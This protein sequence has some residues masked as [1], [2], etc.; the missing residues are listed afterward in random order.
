MGH[1]IFQDILIIFVLAIPVVML[2]HLLRLPSIIGFLTT[3]AIIGPYG[4]GLIHDGAQIDVL[5]E[6][7]VTLLLFVVG[8]EFSFTSLQKLKSQSL[9]GGFLQVAGT[10]IIGVLIGKAL[11]WNHYRVLY[12]GCVLALSSTALVI[13]SLYHNKMLDSLSGQLSTAILIFQDLVFFPM[14]IL[15]PMLAVEQ[16]APTEM[17]TLLKDAGQSLILIIIVTIFGR[18]LAKRILY[19]IFRARSRELLVITIMAVALGMAWLTYRLGFSPALGAFLGG[20]MLGGTEFKYQALSEISPFRYCF[21]SIFFVSIGMLFNFNFVL[22]YWELVLIFALLIPILKASV[23]TLAAILIRVPIRLALVVGICL[24][25]IGEFSFL[26]AYSGQKV[27]V[28]TPFFY[29]LIVVSAVISMVMTPFLV[30]HAPMIADRLIRLPGFRYLAA[31]KQEEA[32]QAKS[33]HLRDHII[34]CGFGPLGQTFGKILN[35]HQLPYIVLELNPHTISR[36]K[37]SNTQVFFGDGASE[38]IL[39]HCGIEHA[40]LLAITVPDFL[41]N[42]AIIQQARKL[43]P[44]IHIITRSKYRNEVDKLYAAGADVVI[45]EELE[46]GIEMGRYALQEVGLNNEEI[47]H[48]IDKLREFGS[49]D[50]F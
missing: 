25:Q 12:F 39:Y 40:R 42:A 45:S 37:Q 35:E 23:A 3:G 22:S 2:I 6:L 15:L 11:G 9:L 44:N 4:I 21:N 7:G 36:I 14:I 49:A 47:D 41:N 33:E 20:L 30:K 8:L 43:N 38:E 13:N 18:L 1:A 16:S 17:M 28:I 10:F 46:G 29:Q 48:F 5:A 34:I 32:A 50:F 26:L 27:G 19:Q 24:A 31:N